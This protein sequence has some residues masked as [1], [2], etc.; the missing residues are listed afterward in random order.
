MW[1]MWVKNTLNWQHVNAV[2]FVF[3][4]HLCLEFQLVFRMFHEQPRIITVGTSPNGLEQRHNSGRPEQLQIH[5]LRCGLGPRSFLG[6]V[7]MVEI[8]GK[9]RGSES[10]Q[11]IDG[12]RFFWDK[13]VEVGTC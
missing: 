3:C 6:V 10:P 2:P 9:I 4:L 11:V 1:A 5:P 12:M 8:N 7:G 13:D